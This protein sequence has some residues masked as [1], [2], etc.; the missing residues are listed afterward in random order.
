MTI[1]EVLALADLATHYKVRARNRRAIGDVYD[2]WWD[3]LN[4]LA[5]VGAILVLVL[6]I[7]Y[8]ISSDAPFIVGVLHLTPPIPKLEVLGLLFSVFVSGGVAAG[9]WIYQDCLNRWTIGQAMRAAATA[10]LDTYEELEVFERLRQLLVGQDFRRSPP[11]LGGIYFSFYSENMDR[12]SYLAA[13]VRS[14]VAQLF[15]KIATQD[16]LSEHLREMP[17]NAEAPTLLELKAY[18]RLT[19]NIFIHALLVLRK[20]DR[21]IIRRYDGQLEECLQLIA[22]LVS[23]RNFSDQLAIL[24][25]YYAIRPVH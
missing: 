20:L 11:A 17:A 3:V 16:V 4:T 12:A 7:G 23:E 15:Q 18:L 9:I 6:W 1:G 14:H 10:I 19:A 21:A 24:K 13:G 8:D 5:L 25:P 22:P 2:G